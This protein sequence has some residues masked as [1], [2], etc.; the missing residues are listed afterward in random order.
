MWCPSR[1]AP[2]TLLAAVASHARN[3]DA[4]AVVAVALAGGCSR[5]VALA[6]IAA[7]PWVTPVIV[8]ALIALPSTMTRLARTLAVKLVALQVIGTER[9]TA[10]RL[11]AFPAGNLPVVGS[12]AIAGDALHV[13]Q[14]RALAS[15][16]VTVTLVGV[17]AKKVADA[18]VALLLRGV[19]V[20]TRL[21]AFTVGS[22]RVVKTPQADARARVAVARLGLINI[23]ATLASA[24]RASRNVGFAVVVVGTPV[25]PLTYVSLSTVTDNVASAW[26]QVATSSMVDTA[27]CSA[28]AW[29]WAARDV[30]SIA[31]V[32]VETNLAPVAVGS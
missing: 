9:V 13:W 19:S 7:D 30:H 11:A 12:A 18:F 29:T 10:A 27:I 6:L 14:A 5:N 23:A 22:L 8:L 32:S 26:I 17:Q 25:A 24:T 4:A 31:R 15:H 21:A 1:E 2:S 16:R 20:V 3:A 28:W